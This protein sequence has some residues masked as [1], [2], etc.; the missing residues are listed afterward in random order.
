MPARSLKLTIGE[1]NW[2]W[3]EL[4]SLL[5]RT[6]KC[7]KHQTGNGKKEIDKVADLDGDLFIVQETGI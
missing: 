4:S 1:R 7:S 3:N 2:K 5:K 6:L